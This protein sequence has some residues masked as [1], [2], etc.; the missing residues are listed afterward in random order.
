M[1]NAQFQNWSGANTWCYH[2]LW[3]L[4][5]ALVAAGWIHVSSSD[6]TRVATD[7]ADDR[8]VTEP[9]FTT[10]LGYWC[11]LQGPSTF[12]IPFTTAP[13]NFVRGETIT[14]AV[15][16][17][18][19]ELVSWVWDGT[20][21]GYA[22]VMTMTGTFDNTHVITGNW[23]QATFTPNG[24]I[25]EFVRQLVMWGCADAA[26]GG[27]G[28]VYYQCVDNVAEATE[29]FSYPDRLAAATK[30]ICPGGASG[31]GA[32]G[33]P[34]NTTGTTGNGTFVPLGLGGANAVT[35][36]AS[37][38]YGAS[39]IVLL[40][41][42]Q[43]LVANATPAAGISPD[44]SFVLAFGTP[45][46]GAGQFVGW[47]FQRL[48]ATEPGDVEIY[49]WVVNNVT[50]RVN[51]NLASGTDHFSI[52]GS[53]FNAN[54]RWPSWRRRGMANY[55]GEGGFVLA[56]PAM[57]HAPGGTP[58]R[59]LSCN[60]TDSERVACEL[61]S[62]WVREPIWVVS[63]N[64]GAKIRKGTLRWLHAVQGN[65]GCDT[66]DN[67]SWIQLSGSTSTINAV[68]AGPADGVT[69]PVNA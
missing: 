55:G 66:Y 9:N 42:V 24:T 46:Q 10:T 18:T 8:W 53:M 31:T 4:S 52:A 6:Q 23:S 48:D 16:G 34:G 51:G 61:T 11:L 35:T 47:A 39:S 15:T 3:K 30:T 56:Q 65:N 40:G 36:S 25:A 14:Q 5:R 41:K 63:L 21:L 49:Q 50:D 17:S 57:L 45:S 62:K 64:P 67:L 38:F 22:V 68:V 33:F 26:L 13:G 43:I 54:S 69:V 32:N 60:Y 20:S 7:P 2:G 44:G 37:A 19:G 12:R 29:M 28:H 27:S 58:V 59:V 1:P